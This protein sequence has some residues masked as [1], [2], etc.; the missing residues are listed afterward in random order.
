M[1]AQVQRPTLTTTTIASVRVLATMVNRRTGEELQADVRANSASYA[2]ATHAIRQQFNYKW[3]I[4]ES[5]VTAEP[6]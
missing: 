2:D 5:W 6:F 3:E 1:I 4:F